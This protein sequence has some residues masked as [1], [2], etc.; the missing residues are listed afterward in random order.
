MTELDVPGPPTSADPAVPTV[1]ASTTRPPASGT[2]ATRATWSASCSG[3]SSRSSSS[4]SSSIASDTSDGLTTDL[5]RAASRLAEAVRELSLA[6]AQVGAI[7]VPLAVV[8]VLVVQRRWRRLGVGTAGGRR[9]ASPCSRWSTPSSTCPAGTE[10][11]LDGDTWVASPGFPSVSLPRGGDR[12]D[13]RREGVAPPVLAAGQRHRPRRAGARAG[14]RRH[15]RRAG[16]A[17][18]AGR[19]TDRGVRGPGGRSARRTGGP[20]RPW[21]ATRWPGPGSR[22]P[23]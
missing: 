15:R 10:G 4:C 12:G 17:P 8:I 7:V 11:A 16:P 5:G 22:S 2:S 13:R 20:P 14:H 6:L 9:P 1:P 23:S 21:S 19:R 18:G 3:R